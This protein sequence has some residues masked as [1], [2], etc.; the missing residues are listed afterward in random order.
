MSIHEPQIRYIA[1]KR[2][3]LSVWIQI[4]LICTLTAH[5]ETAV[6]NPPPVEQLGLQYWRDKFNEKLDYRTPDWVTAVYILLFESEV[7]RTSRAP[8][9][10]SIP[11]QNLVPFHPINR[12]TSIA[13][14][15]RREKVLRDHKN[16]LLSAGIVSKKW[17]TEFLPSQQPIKVIQKSSGQYLVIDG[18]GRLEA[19]TRVFGAES[20]LLVDV[21]FYNTTSPEALIL[22]DIIYDRRYNRQERFA[23]E[24]LAGLC[25]YLLLKKM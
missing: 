3:L 21:E 7:T 4:L 15:E 19:L 13:K 16:E 2:L 10:I 20:Q 8:T 24:S 25:R 6:V 1:F 14:A 17:H 18:N 9:T 5:A 22:A 23:G 12:V 11:I